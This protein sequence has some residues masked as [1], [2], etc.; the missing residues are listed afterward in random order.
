[1]QGGDERL[2]KTIRVYFA[3]NTYKTLPLKFDTTV[4]DVLEWLCR[5]LSAGGRCIDPS[6]CDLFTISL[7]HQ[8]L[9]ERKLQREDTPLQIQ[10]KGGTAF[11]F[12]FRET[13]LQTQSPV[14]AGA[15]QLV[16]PGDAGQSLDADSQ[17]AQPG[18]GM[19]MEEEA[20]GGILSAGCTAPESM[21]AGTGL[22]NLAMGPT[23]EGLLKN[24][25]LE[26]LLEDG[27][28]Y[29]C[30]V[31]LDEDRLWYS[32]APGGEK[33]GVGKY[34]GGMVCLLLRECDG[35]AEVDEKKLLQLN[36]KGGTMTF[37]ARSSNEKTAWLLAVV[38]QAAFVKERDI[39][40]QAEKIIAG[41]EYRRASQQVRNLESFSNLSATL[42]SKE[43]RELLQN[44]ALSEWEE[45]HT[46]QGSLEA[47]IELDVPQ[48]AEAMMRTPSELP[49][50]SSEEM[51]R[52]SSLANMPSQPPRGCLGAPHGGSP[53][54]GCPSMRW[55]KGLI[56]KAVADC[57]ERRAAGED[58]RRAWAFIEETLFP[59]FLEHPGVQYRLCWIAAGIT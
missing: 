11:K 1:M 27:S 7:G 31:I 37:R 23:A 44:F 21:D 36:T 17:I 22:G 16:D 14:A 32:Q 40:L 42:A 24:G 10:A 45:T 59:R 49:S 19:V 57:L 5:R 38:K 48:A 6:R 28:W 39:L 26:R 30:T 56:V 13:L 47:F 20:A 3:D 35:V 2:E 18:N 9:R 52:T 29:P 54:R 4:S 33:D 8:S 51:L 34:G 55:P 46:H 41:T 53:N 25:M 50:P 12:L 58:D 15:E 43:V